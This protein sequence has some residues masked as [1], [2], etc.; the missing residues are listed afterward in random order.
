MGLP[1][2]IGIGICILS[3]DY[4]TN[5]G[6]HLPTTGGPNGTRR[7]NLLVCSEL[8]CPSSSALGS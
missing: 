3:K 1:E 5:E 2:E 6:G 8:G 7:V 4:L